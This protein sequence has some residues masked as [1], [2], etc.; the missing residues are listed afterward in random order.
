M[1]AN[2]NGDCWTYLFKRSFKQ[3]RVTMLVGVSLIKTDE[4][5]VISVFEVAF[6]FA[7]T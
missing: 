4:E 2:E 6:I 5:Y 7:E 1:T 3:D